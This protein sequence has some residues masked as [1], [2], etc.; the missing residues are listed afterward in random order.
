MKKLLLYFLAISCSIYCYSQISFEKGYYI[1]NNNQIVNCLIKNVNW[2]GNPTKFKYKLSKNSKPIIAS[3]KSVK[4]FG[5]DTIFKYIRETVNIDR[6]SDR[7]DDLSQDKN[8]TFKKEELF[9]KVLIEGKANLYSYE[10]GNLRTYFYSKENSNIE[11]LVFKKYLKANNKIG[12][13]NNYKQQLQKDLECP[14]FNISKIENV[15]Y[16]KT[17][18]LKLFVEYNE[19]NNSNFTNF[20]NKRKRD[21]FKLSI[22]PGMNISSLTL[23]NSSS[24]SL[25]VDFGYKFTFRIGIET[26]FILP[27]NR[28]KWAIIIE[29]TFQYYKSEK[30]LNS[31]QSAKVDYKSIEFPLGLRYYFFLSKNSKIFI[32]SLY[33][34]DLSINSFIDLN[35]GNKYD[36]KT[37]GNFAFG[38]G[39]KYYNR[40][41]VEFRYQTSRDVLRS[42]KYL[43]SDYNTLSVIFGYT[44]F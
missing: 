1:D 43:G 37:L 7:I 9:I 39:Y 30:K 27:F 15:N 22:R 31:V 8:P 21:F 4:E 14:T 24:N 25:D 41:S 13:N 17:E 23:Q 36:I 19:C 40:Y 18:L 10:D 11:Q 20:E 35:Y 2:I 3:I 33:I 34:F 12:I 29:P 28:N 42:Y 16:E 5:I 32:N 26:E 6:S 38:L 44:L